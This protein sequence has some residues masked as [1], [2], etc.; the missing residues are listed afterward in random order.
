MRELVVGDA[1]KVH[2]VVNGVYRSESE[3]FVF[4]VWLLLSLFV[5]VFICWFVSAAW[6][7]PYHEGNLSFSMIIHFKYNCTMV[8][9]LGL[10]PELNREKFG[11]EGWKGFRVTSSKEM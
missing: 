9:L 1:D 11:L 3:N 6:C 5:L 7:Q 2:E 8:V 4:L 10:I